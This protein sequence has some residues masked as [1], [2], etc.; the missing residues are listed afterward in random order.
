[1]KKS[2]VRTIYGITIERR[3]RRS[4]FLYGDGF[5]QNMVRILTGT[6]IEIGDGRRQPEEITE[7]LAA[8]ES[9]CAGYTAPACGLTL[10]EVTYGEEEA[11]KNGS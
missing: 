10:L 2:T 9:A 5:L 6:L 3:S 4:D 7:I 8:E 1:M 11:W